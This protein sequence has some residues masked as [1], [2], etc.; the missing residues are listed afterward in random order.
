M[1]RQVEHKYTQMVVN[2][3]WSGWRHS[4][5]WI[6]E[7]PQNLKIQIKQKCTNNQ[8]KQVAVLRAMEYIENTELDDKTITIFTD[9]RGTLDALNKNSNHSCFIETI[10]KKGAELRMTNRE[11]QLCWNKATVGI[12][13]NVMADTLAKEAKTNM[14][15]AENNR[16]IPK[17]AEIRELTERSTKTWQRQWDQTTKGAVTEEYFPIVKERLMM[18]IKITLNST[19]IIT[20]HRNI[21]S[22]LHRFKLT[23]T[24]T[25]TCG[26]SAQTVDHILYNCEIL[27]KE[28]DSLISIVVSQ[29][30]TLLNTT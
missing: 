9:N 15:L 30:T 8:V 29:T 4:N 5:I 17:S 2:R 11:I 14:D 7:T 19:T 6:W 28:R 3:A 23:D 20:G 12:Q 25:C 10:R 16:K 1:N 22:Y 24:P 27:N 13:G 26:K 18:N 21:R